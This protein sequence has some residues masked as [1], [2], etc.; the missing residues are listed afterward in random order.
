MNKYIDENELDGIELKPGMIVQLK[1][2]KDNTIHNMVVVPIGNSLGAIESIMNHET[3]TFSKI[4]FDNWCFLNKKIFPKTLGIEP[5]F[6]DILIEIFPH[7][8]ICSDDEECIIFTH[9]ENGQ[10]LLND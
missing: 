9:K 3:P 10:I 8:G 6:G 1:R 4:T 7:L 2:Y 5:T